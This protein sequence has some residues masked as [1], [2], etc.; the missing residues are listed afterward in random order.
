MVHDTLG[1]P[2]RA[3]VRL[4]A[5]GAQVWRTAR[6]L[7]L[8]CRPGRWSCGSTI[9]VRGRHGHRDARGRDSLERD[10]RLHPAAVELQPTIVTAAKRSQFLD[11]AVTSIALSRHDVARRP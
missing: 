7:P 4:V 3:Y 5:G 9:S 1:Q 11:Q 10:Y 2:L 8:T 6:P